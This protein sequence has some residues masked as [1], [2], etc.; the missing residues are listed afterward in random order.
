M[1]DN[2]LGRILRNDL[3]LATSRSGEKKD[4]QAQGRHARGFT[5]VELLVVISIIGMLMALLLPAVQNARET[6]RRNTCQSNQHNLSLALIQ[7]AEAK[8][9]YPGW[10][11]NLATMTT[12]GVSGNMTVTW[13]VPILPYM[14]K[15][16]VYTALQT[17]NTTNAMVYMN[18][19]ICPS[20]PP[21][22]TSGATPLAYCINGGQN[23]NGTSVPSSNVAVQMTAAA[24]SGIAYDLS[25]A[26]TPSPQGLNTGGTSTNVKVSQDYVVSHDGSTATLLTSENDNIGNQSWTP[27]VANLVTTGANLGQNVGYGQFGLVFQWVGPPASSTPSTMPPTGYYRINGNKG[28]APTPSINFARPASNHPGGVVVSFCGGNVR[29]IAEDIAYYVYKQLMTPY[30]NGASTQSTPP[31]D[32]DLYNIPLNENAF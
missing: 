16:D 2:A 4:E 1:C 28:T 24:S 15:S 20:N 26:N 23:Y 14:E 5:L 19:L 11:N 17:G 3:A 30:G 22:T 21:T 7:F 18:I 12:A 27:P 25:L 29:F 8:K 9:Y 32:T 10:D 6:G 31:G 13:V